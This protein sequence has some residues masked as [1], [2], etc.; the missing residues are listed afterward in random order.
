M[1]L[2]N[3]VILQVAPE[4]KVPI[5]F[6]HLRDSAACWEYEL[7]YWRRSYRIRNFILDL[8]Q[9]DYNDT[10]HYYEIPKDRVKDIIKFLSS[11]NRYNWPAASFYEWSFAKKMLRHQIKR[12]KKLRKI[13]G[14]YRL[15][16]IDSY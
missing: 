13:R 4:T 5:S 9:E 10:L 2:D 3:Y 8:V 1:G 14:D 15:I 6:E 7:C 12:L 16:F 11:F